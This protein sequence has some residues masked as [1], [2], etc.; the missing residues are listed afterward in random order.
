MIEPLAVTAS[1]LV[2]ACGVGKEATHQA[3]VKEKTG[4]SQ[5]GYPGLNFSTWLGRVAGVEEQE[6]EKTLSRYKCR[7]NQLAN[8]ALSIDGFREQVNHAV[9][10]YGQDRI[11]VFVGT[12]T[13][14]IEETEKAY[15]EKPESSMKLADDF[16]LLATHNIAS[17]LMYVQRSLDLK[18]PGQSISTA[19]SSSAKVFVAAHRH[20]MS[21]LC[22]AAVVGGVDSLC[23]T[24]LYGFNSLQ[25]V[26]EEICRP[27]DIDR[28]G[29]NIGEAA[30]FVLL[31]REEQGHGKI[32]LKGYGE[33]SDAYH[34][35][36]P[37]PSGDGALAAM[38][39]ALGKAGLQAAQ[40]DYINTHGTATVSNDLAESQGLIRLFGEN[41]LCSSTK[42]YTGH[43]LG[44]AGITEAMIAML[45][46]EQDIIP[47]TVNLKEQDPKIKIS[48]VQHTQRKVVGNVMTNN[49]GFGGSNCSLIFGW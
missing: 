1:T 21:G 22:D 46:L 39:E 19:C 4:L 47:A 33:S 35:S 7:N 37:H 36:S 20:I 23:L 28:K 26:S 2:N 6:I 29:I 32:K 42:G 15:R 17:L 24:T 13:S 8:L 16:D 48:P 27:Y 31:E 34:M 44:A 38:Q 41:V 11:G 45:T 49:F 18:G 10:K 30:G 9:E 3:I 12:S 14:G 43:T 5:C 40:I 25:L